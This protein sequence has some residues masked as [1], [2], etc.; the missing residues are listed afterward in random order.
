[1]KELIGIVRVILKERKDVVLSIVFG[2]LA[3]IAAV[4]LFAA[5]GYLISQAALHPPIYVLISM[6]AIVKIGSIIRAVS[7]Y[8]ERYFSHR[9]TFTMLSDLRTYFYEKLEN[10]ANHQI[11]QFRSGDLLARIVGDI[12]S[13]QN[14]FLRVLYPPIIMFT[15]FFSTILFVSHYTPEVVGLLTVGLVITGI[16]IPAWFAKRQVALSNHLKGERAQLSTEVTEWFYGYR[17]LKIHQQLK[18]KEQQLISASQSYISQQERVGRQVNAN[19]SIN[20]AA[21]SFTIWLIIVVSS[22]LV[23]T[24]QLDGLFLAM[25]IMICITVFDYSTPMATFSTYYEESERSAKRLQNVVSVE[26]INDKQIAKK[27]ELPSSGFSITFQN[28]SFTFPD[29]YRAQIKG[30]NLHLEAGSKTAIVGPS[31]SGKSTILNLLLKFYETNQGE[32][33]LGDAPI[34]LLKQ[35]QIWDQAKVVLQNNHFFSGTIKD[36]LLLSTNSLSD[37]EIQRLLTEVWLPHFTSSYAVLEK[38]Q[39]LSGGEKQRLAMARASAKNG[40]LWILDEPTSSLDNLTEQY[41]YEFLFNQAKD[42]TVILV[43]H[44]LSNLEK[45]D[46]IIVMDQ[47]LII[48][49]GTYSELLERKGYFFQLKQ[50][51]ANMI[52]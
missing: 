30:F 34:S 46:Q 18:E 37:V 43:S 29:A 15:V 16:I 7:R 22:Y 3:G 25:V 9:A 35:E 28:V 19:Y 41:L 8:G 49:R 52:S 33:L 39:N 31:G 36:N 47:G 10:M 5:N 4:G 14:L 32:I 45:M 48:E 51:E 1:M 13:L 23:A 24:D 2:Y 44:R 40:S 27:V 12:E 26:Q 50:L 11:Q 6:I 17:E 20:Q 38:G 21:S 42:H